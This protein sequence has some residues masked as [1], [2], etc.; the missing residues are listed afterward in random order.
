[1][2]EATNEQ[3]LQ[4]NGESIKFRNKSFFDTAELYPTC[5]LRAE[6]AGDTERIRSWL[7]KINHIEKII[8]ASKVVGKRYK[9]IRKW[10]AN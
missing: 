1:M 3:E 2:G 7:K 5:P 9:A 4:T 6:T 8:L 10:R